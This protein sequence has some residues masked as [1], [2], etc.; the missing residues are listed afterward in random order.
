MELSFDRVLAILGALGILIGAGV[1]IAT[2]ARAKGEML[3]A[4]GCFVISGLALC[5]TAGIWLFSTNLSLFVRL[6]GT[7]ALA[8]FVCVLTIQ[9]NRWTERRYRA[10]QSPISSLD[11]RNRSRMLSR[12]RMDWIDGMLM[13]SLWRIA[14]IE[15]GLEKNPNAVD[16]RPTYLFQVPGQRSAPI[17]PGTSIARLFDEAGGA[18]LILGAPGTGKTTLLLELAKDLLDRAESDVNHP[19]PVVFNLS[20]WSLQRLPLDQWLIAELNER[21]DVPK[22]V[23]EWWVG[24]E[25]VVPLLDGLDEVAGEHRQACTNAINDFRRAHGLVPIALCSRTVD[26]EALRTKV[27]LRSAV[28]VRPLTSAQIRDYLE[29]AGEQL[30]QLKTA[31]SRDVSLLE[32]LESPLML[33]VAMLA[34]RDAPVEFSRTDSPKQRRRRI[35][36]KFVETMLRRRSTGAPYTPAK[37]L[38]WLSRLASAMKMNEQTVFNLEMLSEPWLAT[39]ALRW[40]SRAGLVLGSGTLGALTG[41]LIGAGF[42][43]WVTQYPEPLWR[44]VGGGLLGLIVGSIVGLGSG[45][46]ALF[47]EVR[48]VEAVRFSLLNVSTRMRKATRDALVVSIVAGSLFALVG[49]LNDGLFSGRFTVSLKVTVKGIYAVVVEAGWKV[50]LVTG[51]SIGL[52]MGLI[53]L[54]SAEMLRPRTMPGQGIHRSATIALIAAL[55]SAFISGFFYWLSRGP[56]SALP[57]SVTT[58]VVVGL[59][60]G[61][62]FCIK[63]VTLRLILWGKRS[64]P[65]RYVRFLNY[66]SALL[67]LRRVGGGYVF[68]HRILLE[69]FASLE[70]S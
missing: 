20:S 25:Q 55:A 42:G 38:S 47:I 23:A 52:L 17:P 67:F 2:A 46:I 58:A 19:I 40:L 68:V 26:Y 28:V 49:L 41:T 70:K 32:I 62:L 11:H 39:G 63:H 21:S 16:E 66:A 14:R 22:R 34:Y 43:P 50:G 48:P 18:L 35:F 57:N 45:L 8:G 56:G 60:G 5:F 3:F 7:V 13:Q 64:A 15:L 37:T 24:S 54:L 44:L 59:F 30:K 31:L 51:M 10:E 33:W 27:R 29:S 1:A 61:G 53:A 65:L 69:Y 36:A 9:A 4:V 12:V 6:S